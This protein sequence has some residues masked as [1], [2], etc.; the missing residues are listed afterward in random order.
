VQHEQ[1]FIESRFDSFDTSQSNQLEIYE[2]K[3]FLTSLNDY[4]P[5]TDKEARCVCSCNQPE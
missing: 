3:E 5:V 4:I 2:L 1:A